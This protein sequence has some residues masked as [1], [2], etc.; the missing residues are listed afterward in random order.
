MDIKKIEELLKSLEKKGG[1]VPDEIKKLV[2]FMDVS[3]QA[4]YP[5]LGALWHPPGG[6]ARHDAVVWTYARAADAAGDD[7]G[8]ATGGRQGQRGGGPPGALS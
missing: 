4:R 3:K 7:P 2:P 6:I 1:V 8:R 5:I